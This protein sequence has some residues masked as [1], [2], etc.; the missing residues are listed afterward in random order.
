MWKFH[1]QGLNLCYSCNLR[2]SCGSAESLIC[3]TTGELPKIA[4]FFFSVFRAVPAAY[5]SS[6]ARG[7]SELQLPAYTT[8]VTVWDLSCICSPHHSSWECRIPDHWAR[9]GIEPTS[10]WI[11]VGFISAAPQWELPKNILI[12]NSHKGKWK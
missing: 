11:L 12:S 4:F 10:S 6:Q 3:C 2:Y 8:V 9:P 7:E 5:G 1:D